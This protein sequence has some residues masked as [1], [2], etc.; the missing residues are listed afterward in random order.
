MKNEKNFGVTLDGR[1]SKLDHLNDNKLER[2]LTS[3]SGCIKI[4]E[5]K[6]RRA[7]ENNDT[8]LIEK[9]EKEL[10]ELYKKIN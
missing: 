7:K 4:R 8:K 9:L 6:L 2:K 1:K 3:G 10:S 5:M